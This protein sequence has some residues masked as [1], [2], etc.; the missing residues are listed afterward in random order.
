MLFLDGS[1][2]GRTAISPGDRGEQLIANLILSSI[3]YQ[4]GAVACARAYAGRDVVPGRGG[5]FSLENGRGMRF[6]T[7]SRLFT[8][9]ECAELPPI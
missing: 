3:A 1:Q 7:R 5:M 2:M 4:F 8:D 6:L 9:D